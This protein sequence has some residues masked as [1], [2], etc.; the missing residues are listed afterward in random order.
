M[1]FSLDFGINRLTFDDKVVFQEFHTLLISAESIKRMS[2]AR[3]FYRLFQCRVVVVRAIKI[4]GA[5]RN[6]GQRAAAFEKGT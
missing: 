4:R 2:D 1:L 6:L 3:D 5:G